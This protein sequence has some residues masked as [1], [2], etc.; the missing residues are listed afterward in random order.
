MNYEEYH[1][2][3]KDVI[4]PAVLKRDG[5]K[6]VVCKIR[7]KSRVYKNSRGNYVEC[8]EFIEEWAKKQ[9]FKV[10][11]LHLNV[12]HLDHNK[13]NNDLSN[14]QA[15]CP[16]HHAQMDAERKKL[17]RYNIK[18]QPSEK[19]FLPAVSFTT[20]KAEKLVEVR[21][22]VRELTGVSLQLHECEVIYNVISKLV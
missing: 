14:L 10:F 18:G 22:L 6:C 3:W 15:M 9:G 11:T 19:S 4:R 17:A 8:D 20:N 5:Y 12:A 2:D 16:K 13:K 21:R 7:H 1:P